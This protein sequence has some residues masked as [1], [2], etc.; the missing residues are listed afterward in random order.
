[1]SVIVG[2]NGNDDLNGTANSD[3]I[4]SGNGADTIDAGDGNDLIFSGNGADT[5]DAGGGNDVVFAGNGDDTVDGGDGHDLIFGGR[6]DDTINGGAGNDLIFGGKG[7]D[8]IDGGEGCDIIAAGSGNDLVIFDVDQNSGAQNYFSGG[9]GNDTLR[10]RLTQAQVNEMTAAGVF[11]AF[12]NHV[13]SHSGFD[14]STF[15]LSFAINLKVWRFEQIEVE[16]TGSPGLFTSVDDTVDF[17]TVVAGSYTDGTQYD[18]L[19]GNDTVTLANDVAAAA[20]A[21]YVVG[22]A[23]NAGAGD[24]TV[25]GGALDDIINGDAGND[26][27]NGG[28]GVDV[29]N[30]GDDDDRLILEDINVGDSVD[31]GTGNDTFVFAAANRT[32]HRIEVRPTEVEYDTTTTISVINVEAYELKMADGNDVVLISTAFTTDDIINGLAGNDILIAGTGL[33]MVFGGAGNDSITLNDAT[34]GDSVDGGADTDTFVYREFLTNNNTITVSLTDVTVDGTAISYINIETVDINA[35]AGNDTITGSANNDILRGQADDDTISGGDGN[36]I[37][38]G[39]T[40]VDMLFGDAGND[41]LSLNDA[42]VGDSVDGGADTDTFNYIADANANVITINPG[43]VT[44]DGVAITV[45]NIETIDINAG[46]GNDSVTGSNQNETLR[47]GADDDTLDGGTGNDILQGGTGNDRLILGDVN[48]GDNV[49]GGADNDTFVY[50]VQPGSDHTIT[51]SA[52][53]V[54]VDGVAISVVDVENY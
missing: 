8:I 29:L 18:G 25:N 11:A 33:D 19:D 41:T 20:A 1:M 26:V 49:N 10:L 45:S 32:N 27:L 9:S 30:G 6:G 3:L 40:G 28:T 21:G 22:T 12:A 42:N 46:A 35:G 17:N 36:D 51:T 7:D 14:F 13:G 15:G 54:I 43:D 24:D 4:I 47:G 34:V 39:G 44:V 37:I 16:L 48:L 23:F 2:T 5:I 31:G 52:T 50:A 53:Q 38:Q